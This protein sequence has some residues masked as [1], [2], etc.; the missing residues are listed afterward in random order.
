MFIPDLNNARVNK[1]D[2]PGDHSPA[3]YY[4][5]WRFNNPYTQKEWLN[6]FNIL[7]YEYLI[8]M[9]LAKFL[10][11][12]WIYAYENCEAFFLIRDIIDFRGK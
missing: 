7:Y 11:I 3:H 10:L 1:E 9:K 4:H 6:K 5:N 12:L 2:F 8:S